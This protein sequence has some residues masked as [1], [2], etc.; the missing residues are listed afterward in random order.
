MKKLGRDSQYREGF[1]KL[2]RECYKV[3]KKIE[4]IISRN[5]IGRENIENARGICKLLEKLY[6]RF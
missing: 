2:S 5:K 6:E 1:G 3:E 4:K